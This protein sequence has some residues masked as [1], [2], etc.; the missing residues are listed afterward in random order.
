[1]TSFMLAFVCTVT[2]LKSV[3]KSKRPWKMLV[4][5]D[6]NQWS[7]VCEVRLPANG[8][9]PSNWQYLN[10]I[11]SYGETKRDLNSK[12]VLQESVLFPAVRP[13]VIAAVWSSSTL[14]WTTTFISQLQYVTYAQMM[15]I[16]SIG[17][18]CASF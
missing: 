4:L 6:E 7:L 9:H 1:M 11:E 16:L 18:V 14:L 15:M 2:N 8:L 5:C 3:E 17:A 10:D 12:E 13:P